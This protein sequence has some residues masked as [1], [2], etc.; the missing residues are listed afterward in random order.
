MATQ[1]G[2]DPNAFGPFGAMFESYLSAV[3]AFG[4]GKV[5][6]AQG[7]A[8]GFDMQSLTQQM[9]GPLKATARCQLEMLGLAN[10][11]AQAYMQVP[12]RLAQCRTPQ[13]L[14]NEQMAFW[15]TASDQYRECAV[16]VGQAWGQALPW[17][18]AF[19]PGEAAERDYITFNSGRKE[20]GA[21]TKPDPSGTQRRVA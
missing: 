15:R 20:T 19:R 14:I 18:Q 13:D 11:R 12:T 3:D 8:P 5:P 10:R 7:L 1:S 16:K 6:G 21:Q 9:T 2:F 17:L 4:Q